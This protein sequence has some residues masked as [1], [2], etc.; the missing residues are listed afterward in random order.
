M[1]AS[2][3]FAVTI[4]VGRAVNG[5]RAREHNMANIAFTH[6]LEKF[7]RSAN[8]VATVKERILVRLTNIGVQA[9]KNLHLRQLSM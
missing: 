5:A 4:T 9:Y 6:R 8:I 3:G 7:N 2:A 1:F